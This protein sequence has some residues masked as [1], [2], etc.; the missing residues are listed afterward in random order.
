ICPVLIGVA[1]RGNGVLRLLKALRHEAPCVADTVKRLGLKIG[2]DPAAY[3]LKS[4][5]TSHGGKLSIVRVLAGQVGGG[6]VFVTP[7]REAGRVSG[8]FN[9]T[10]QGQEKRGAAAAGETIAFGKLDYARTGDTLTAAKQ[11]LGAVPVPSPQAP[12]LAISVSAKERKD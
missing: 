2:S 10:G 8:V 5:Q 4:L 3:V 7:E 1:T 11:A 6:T 12:V 9:L